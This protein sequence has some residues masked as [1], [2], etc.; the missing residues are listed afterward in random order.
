[1]I[2]YARLKASPAFAALRAL[3]ARLGAEPLQVQGAGGNTSLKAGG[4]MWIKASGTWL[5]E[6]ATR[7]IMVPVNAERLLAAVERGDP[8]CEN[9]LDFVPH[10]ETD[11]ALRPSIETTLH[12]VIPAPVVIHTH[13]VATIATAMRADA[14]AVTAA[15]LGDMGA[16]HVPY[17]KPGLAL[18]QAILA[19]LRADTRVVVLGNH[20]LI[21]C[22][23]TCAE[24][25]ATLREA[26]RR[27]EPVVAPQD[28]PAQDGPAP[29]LAV[30][31]SPAHV[32]APG[33]AVNALARHPARLAI[34]QRGSW[35][36]DHV[37]FLG[38]AVA[39]AAPGETAAAASARVTAD[40]GRAPV[41]ILLPGLGAAIRADASPG[42]RALAQCLGDVMAR[43]DPAAPLVALTAAQE[44]ELMD[45]D[46]EKYRQSL[47][48][49]RAGA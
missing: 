33:A 41:L 25:E 1:M 21:A 49:A 20:G 23:E 10:G 30:L 37:I 38:P 17:V 31:L 8:D 39:V 27:L 48:A 24:A 12:A 36:P 11:S 3:S 5:A 34:A 4:A 45:W 18:A 6:A 19:R 9:A 2:P 35:Y 22:G 26:S 16:I 43:A 13:C 28:G 44:A 7:D 32:A 15:Q 29:G 14:A 47:D 40:S 46:A 42:A